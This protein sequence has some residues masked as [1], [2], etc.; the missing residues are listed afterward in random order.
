MTEFL[1]FGE[2]K[3]AIFA[4]IF[5]TGALRCA[6]LVI[7]SQSAI[8]SAGAAD[9]LSPL[10]PIMSK[11]QGMIYLITFLLI[12]ARWKSAL[13][14]ALRNKLLWAVIALALVSTLWSELP[15]V[16]FRRSVVIFQAT[17]FGLYLASRYSL[18][19][20][21]QLTAWALA[22]STVFSLLFTLALPGFAIESGSHAGAWRGPLDHKNLLA[23][24]EVLSALTLLLTALSNSRYRYCLW[25]GCSLAICLVVLT[26]SQSGL[27]VLLALLVLLP[28][29]KALRLSTTLVIPLFIIIVIVAAGAG[30]L[31]TENL[32]PL[33]TGLGRDPSLSGRSVIWG[34]VFDKLS[35]RPW[36]GYGFGGFWSEGS[37]GA[38]YVTEVNRFNPGHGHSGFVNLAADLGWFG[39]SLFTLSFLLA[40]KRAFTWVSLGKTADHLWPVMFLTFLLIY[41]FT[42]STLLEVNSIFWVLYASVAL[43]I[44]QL[45]IVPGSLS[46]INRKKPV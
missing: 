36:L 46:D 19:E 2:K 25:A 18:K 5:F 39:V 15:G 34:A 32:E 17:V 4:L 40:C 3:F 10:D 27:L 41:N 7:P 9:I 29:Y 26:T 44:K 1:R 11:V 30:A 14:T 24:L 20:Q 22:T 6:S 28:L 45:V 8:S 21:L 33:L 23:R 35:E 43:S 38:S 13:I 16:T 31:I 37:S 42:E 12:L